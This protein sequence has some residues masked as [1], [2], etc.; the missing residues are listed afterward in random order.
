MSQ[1]VRPISSI[2]E[3]YSAKINICQIS[4]M[5]DLIL[6]AR[7]AQV[8][9]KG[10]LIPYNTGKFF[11]Y[12]TYD[13]TMFKN[14]IDVALVI[15]GR[16]LTPDASQTYFKA[17]PISLSNL[18]LFTR[19]INTATEWMHDFEK[20]NSIFKINGPELLLTDKG[21]DLALTMTMGEFNIQLRPSVMFISDT[22]YKGVQLLIS[23]TE[24]EFLY[25]NIIDFNLYAMAQVLNQLD[26][27]SV[28]MSI[29]NM[30]GTTKYEAKFDDTRNVSL[31][32]FKSEPVRY[33]TV[34]QEKNKGMVR[35][36]KVTHG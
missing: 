3:P 5:C 6:T 18:F 34:N 10:I 14:K 13:L 27:V 2:P 7:L 36:R 25:T 21:K 15:E 1:L 35:T 24:N 11:N 19:I 29:L 8:D 9:R 23:D 22:Y 17:V 30:Y 20:R 16:F 32:S 33:D 28:G 31:G 12:K 4:S 26:V